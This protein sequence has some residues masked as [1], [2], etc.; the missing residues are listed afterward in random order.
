[1]IWA[2]LLFA[3]EEGKE[4]QGQGNP[5]LTFLPLILIGVLFWFLII[6]PMKRQEQERKSMASNLRKN[7]RVL[8]I[9]GIY[10]TVVA[11]SETED[12]ITLKVDE[13]VRMKMTKGSVARNLSREEELKESKEASKEQK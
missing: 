6:R 7:D 9:G 12:E 10:G 2:I 13:N 1:M 11:V 4:G 8:T 3:A 5:L